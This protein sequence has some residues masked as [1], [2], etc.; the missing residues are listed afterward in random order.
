[1][2]GGLYKTS[3]RWSVGRPDTVVSSAPLLFTH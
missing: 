1:M 2:Q 3:F